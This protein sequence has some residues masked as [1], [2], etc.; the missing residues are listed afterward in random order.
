MDLF[1]AET[2]RPQVK[3]GSDKKSIFIE[4]ITTDARSI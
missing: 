2:D 3:Q 4:R 1:N